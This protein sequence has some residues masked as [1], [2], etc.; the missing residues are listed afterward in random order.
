MPCFCNFFF[1]DAINYR[2]TNYCTSTRRPMKFFDGFCCFY[3]SFSGLWITELFRVFVIFGVYSE[4][5]D[6]Q[7]VFR[8]Y[9]WIL[10]SLVIFSWSSMLIFEILVLTVL[11]FL[12]STRASSELLVLHVDSLSLVS[13]VI[14][15]SYVPPTI[16]QLL[17]WRA[18]L[19]RSFLIISFLVG[20]SDLRNSV[21]LSR[22]V[23]SFLSTTCW[24]SSRLYKLIF[25][26]T[27][28]CIKFLISFL[29]RVEGYS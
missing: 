29:S 7:P 5:S 23:V 11:T 1:V 12:D 9:S 3:V 6:L 28:F 13:W 25:C 14:S 2:I 19:L 27:S 8:R 10:F 22:L 4:D 17:L 21:S 16:L 20:I 24:Y 18:S 15:K 26:F